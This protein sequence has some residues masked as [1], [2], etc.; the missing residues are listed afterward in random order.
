[1][2]LESP[3][4]MS[5]VSAPELPCDPSVG[6][7]VMWGS[8]ALP[9]GWI[10]C[11]GST[12]SADDY[13]RLGEPG[14][15]ASFYH[16]RAS[17]TYRV[18]DL[19]GRFIRG[20]D[21]G[22]G[23]D[24]EAASR[25][26]MFDRSTVLGAK[27]P[28][29]IQTSSYGSHTH[30]YAMFPQPTD[31]EKMVSELEFWSFPIGTGVLPDDPPVTDLQAGASSESR[32]LNVYLYF[33]IYVGPRTLPQLHQRAGATGSPP[34]APVAAPPA[35]P[36]GEAPI[37]TIALWGCS[38][39][40]PG[41]L[42]CDGKTYLKSDYKVLAQL[43]GKSFGSQP[44]SSFAVP[45]LQGQFIRGVDHTNGQRD[46]DYGSRNR[47]D[48][49]DIGSSQE[50][51][52]VA[53]T[54]GY[55][56]FPGVNVTVGWGNMGGSCFANFNDV[57]SQSSGGKETRPVNAAFFYIVKASP[58]QSTLSTLPVGVIVMWPSTEDPPTGWARCDGTP[59]HMHKA[60]ALYNVIGDTFRPDTSA[61]TTE[62]YF[63]LPDLQG[64]FVRGVDPVDH[65][66]ATDPDRA[67]RV[68]LDTALG[69]KKNPALGA[70]V[71]SYQASAL[72]SHSHTLAGGTPV[73]PKPFRE[74][75]YGGG[76]HGWVGQHAN[77][78]AGTQAGTGKESRPANIYLEFIIRVSLSG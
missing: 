41:W 29:S 56:K 15:V 40:P 55:M 37:G 49:S 1:M 70:K 66:P 27:E 62:G 67:S 58:L 45:N 10:V 16:D 21:G 23:N 2:S 43:L 51:A 71:G 9:A 20:V 74:A 72:Q 33:I 68:D 32:P 25:V 17:G 77:T 64:A 42:V 22:A 7:I 11:D 26:D 57:P 28:Y 61:E 48:A 73:P 39:A 78:Q 63:Y 31:T 47:N 4:Q 38:T 59:L 18:P 14:A 52:Y 12:V 24:P 46:P 30:P 34:P 75:V 53:H 13:P 50:G 69:V 19:R 36:P 54:H 65:T 44:G 35:D 8:D 5:S 76:F 60:Q 6:T 3:T